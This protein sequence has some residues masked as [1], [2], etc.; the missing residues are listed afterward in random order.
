MQTGSHPASGKRPPK[1][2]IWSKETHFTLTVYSGSTRPSRDFFLASTYNGSGASGGGC[3]N[4]FL[5]AGAKKENC[6]G[7]CCPIEYSE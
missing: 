5:Q 7:T 4:V 1:V 2:G 3:S 6:V